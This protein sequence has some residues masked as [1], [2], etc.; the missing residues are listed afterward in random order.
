LPIV[1]YLV[2]GDKPHLIA[3]E[4]QGCAARFFD[5]R[6]ACA[7]CFGIAFATVDLPTIGTLDTFT[8]VSVAAPGVPVPFVA[9]VVNCDGTS[10]RSNVVNVD[11]QDVYLGMPLQ[12]TTCGIGLDD[13]GNEAVGFGFE[14]T[15]RAD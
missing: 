2:L 12:L 4:C 6:D 3:H 8:I 13:N 5:H 1:D 9:G 15:N 14:P 10:V 11:P 7:A